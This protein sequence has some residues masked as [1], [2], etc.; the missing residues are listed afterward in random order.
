[1]S[2]QNQA[3]LEDDELLESN[4]HKGK[5]CDYICIG[6]P[7]LIMAYP[8]IN[9]ISSS[10]SPDPLCKYYLPQMISYIIIDSSAWI[11]LI[12]LILVKGSYEKLIMC[13]SLVIMAVASFI[14]GGI[15]IS[16]FVNV[17][18]KMLAICHVN[19][20]MDIYLYLHAY[21]SVLGMFLLPIFA[22]VLPAGGN[23][24]DP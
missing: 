13:I 8:I 10:P 9:L 4:E 16:F 7:V 15:N 11:F 12:G 19:T 14:A 23:G 22:F 18:H 1:M 3:N 5:L 2:Y 21:L 17:N 6:I 20:Y 24:R